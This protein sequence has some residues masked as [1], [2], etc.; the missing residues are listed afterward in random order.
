M[1]A[2]TLAQPWPLAF[3]VGKR[4]ENRSWAPDAASLPCWVALH[5][6]VIP[7][8]DIRKVDPDAWLTKHARPLD[9]LTFGD[10]Q[11]E[12]FDGCGSGVCWT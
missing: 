4:L 10:D 8:R 7:T 5:G 9:S 6:G 12:L 11:P 2:L 3:R 1:K